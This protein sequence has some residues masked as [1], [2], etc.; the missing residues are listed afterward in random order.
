MGF[1][2]DGYSK[3]Y[4]VLIS[5]AA[6][7][8]LFLGLVFISRLLRLYGIDNWNNAIVLTAMVFWTNLFYYTVGEPGMSHIYSFAFIAMFLYYGR[9]YFLQPAAKYIFLL[10]GLAAI[11]CLIRP[12]NGLV[13]LSLPFLSANRKAW[14]DGFSWLFAR[15][16]LCVSVVVFAVLILSIQP[17]IY[18]ISTGDY[19]VYSYGAETFDFLHP[20]IIDILF[21]YKKGLFLYSPLLLLALS[22]GYVLWKKSRFE[23]FTLFSFLFILTYFLS[24][25]WNW[26]YGGSFSSRVY[27]EYIPFFAI[28]LGLSLKSIQ[29]KFLLTGFKT[30]I[31]VFIVV[32]QIQTFQYRY[33]QIHWENMTR[34]KYWNVF[35]RVDKLL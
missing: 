12:V 34:E 29:N 17:V 24:S 32:C 7:F 23:F 9:C 2:P 31:V 3:P 25:W 8:Y 16:T 22:G 6:L 28:L 21:S 14:K 18:K 1:E 27:L 20:H 30:L 19:W 11:I 26:W 4:P 10:A 15:K 35:L 13:V 33:Y 5:L